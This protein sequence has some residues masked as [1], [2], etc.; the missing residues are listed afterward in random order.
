MARWG[1]FTSKE[2]ANEWVGKMLRYGPVG[3]KTQPLGGVHATRL[4]EKPSNSTPG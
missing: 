3:Q 1:V 2:E 4:E